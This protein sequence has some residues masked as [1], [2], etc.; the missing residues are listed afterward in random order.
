MQLKILLILSFDIFQS[1]VS[2]EEERL[3]SL[4]R[5]N[6]LDFNAWTALIHETEKEVSL[7]SLFV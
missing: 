5:S 2:S 7:S 6:C 4:V 1:D 3:W